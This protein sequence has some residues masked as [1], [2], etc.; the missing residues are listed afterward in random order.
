MRIYYALNRKFIR[1]KEIT[2]RAKMSV[3]NTVFK[4][5]LTYGS[6]S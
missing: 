1:K 3:Y 6:E 2:P 5:I 4:P